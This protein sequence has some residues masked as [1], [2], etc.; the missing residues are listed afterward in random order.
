MQNKLRFLNVS[1]FL[2]TQLY[3]VPFLL[4]FYQQNGLTV[5]DFFLFQGI[6]S[7]SA[8]LF[9]IPSGY[10]AD[11]FPK[12]NILVLS[13]L[14]Y[15]ARLILWL[16]FAQ[17]G[18]WIFLLAEIMFAAHKATWAGCA[19]SYI[20]EYL[21]FNN[22]PQKMKRRYG[23]MNFFMALGTAF[24][25]LVGA[26]IY[27][28]I[29]QYTLSK[30]N[31]NYGFMV[32]ICLELILNLIATGL[33]FKIPQIPIERHQKITLIQSYKTLFQTVVWTM[34][35]KNIKYHILYSGLLISVTSVFAWS[36]QPIMKLLLFPVSL[37]GLVYFINHLLRALGS[38]YA[39]KINNFITLPK[40]G[41][42]CFSLFTCSFIFTF[43]ILNFR[44]IP[45][46]LFL[47]YFVFVTLAIGSQ[48]TFFVL[49]VSRLHKFIPSDRRA[50][51]SSVNT[52]IGRLYAG[53]FF[54]L[55]KI[56]LDG[57]SIQKS[58]VICFVIFIIAAFPLKKVYSISKQEEN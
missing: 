37:Y 23:K 25:S 30:Y 32:L 26:G 33:L 12:R 20:Y 43:I 3:M 38:L 39:P 21:K 4:L 57:V 50:T 13:Y 24:S 1:I 58:L 54:I 49:N 6:F 22:I 47:S 28:N 9:D 45:V 42:L 10:L 51:V 17:Y 18:F 53:F 46:W 11:I 44:S 41:L 2:Q 34:K 7:L 48:V 15:I 27:A 56:C 52:A 40:I 16:F 8:I 31:Y 55:M 36:F 5:G 29:S 19:D 35:N 14:F